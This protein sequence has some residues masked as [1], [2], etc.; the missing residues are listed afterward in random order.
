MLLGSTTRKQCPCHTS[1]RSHRQHSVTNGMAHVSAG[2]SLNRN[3]DLQGRR[4][5]VPIEVLTSQVGIASQVTQL[6]R[7]LPAEHVSWF[8]PWSAEMHLLKALRRHEGGADVAVAP[9]SICSYP[10]FEGVRWQVTPICPAA[11][12]FAAMAHEPLA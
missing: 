3:S 2:S 6:C 7:N 10:C 1:S 12:Q 5:H 4:H 11:L 8:T 9:A